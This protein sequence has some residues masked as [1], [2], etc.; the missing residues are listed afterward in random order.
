MAAKP[1]ERF[2]KR[3]IQ[4]QGGWDRIVERIASGETVTEIAQRVLRPDGKAISRA[5]LSRLLHQDHARSQRVN[6]ARR[7][8]AAA[9]VDDALRIVD[10]SPMDRDAV[11]HSKARAELRLKVAGLVDREAWG[12][13]PMTVNVGVNVGEM[14]LGA[15]RHREVSSTVVD[16]DSRLLSDGSPEQVALST[17]R[18][19]VERLSLPQA[20]VMQHQ[21][22]TTDNQ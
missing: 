22:D 9:M 16:A 14:H 8:G 15:L 2:V 11:Q 3:Q 20:T 4:E 17:Q 21:A 6:Q 5:F 10:T 18:A 13:R 1:I 12:E 19:G 7:E